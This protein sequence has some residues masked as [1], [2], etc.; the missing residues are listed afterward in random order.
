MLFYF[1]SF[2]CAFIAF[3]AGVLIDLDHVI[4]FLLQFNIKR[5][6]EF[7]AI[8]YRTEQSR[9]YILMHSVEMLL[10]LWSAI[11]LI[12]LNKHWIALAIG[13]TQHIALDVIFNPMKS[14]GYFLSYRLIN[15]FDKEKLFK[16]NYNRMR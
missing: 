6:K 10:L 13:F 7:F 11:I 5:F 9:I 4:D 2:L 8:M 15:S 14:T 16:T 3:A 1:R 12:P